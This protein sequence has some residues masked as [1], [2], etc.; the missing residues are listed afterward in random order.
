MGQT[1]LV[2]S[3]EPQQAAPQRMSARKRTHKADDQSRARAIINQSGFS[4]MPT[5]TNGTK[6]S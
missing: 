5:V 6:L 3:V 2:V 4:P 1:Q